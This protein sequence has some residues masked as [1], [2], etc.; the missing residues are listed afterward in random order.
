MILLNYILFKSLK[1]IP[2]YS[3]K[4]FTIVYNW[5]SIVLPLKMFLKMQNL[6]WAPHFCKKKLCPKSTSTHSQGM[7]LRIISSDRNVTTFSRNRKAEASKKS[8]F[9]QLRVIRMRHSRVT[10]EDCLVRKQA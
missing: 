4:Y 7:L 2:L 9:Y 1:H 8:M 6:K 3:D 10:G 5:L